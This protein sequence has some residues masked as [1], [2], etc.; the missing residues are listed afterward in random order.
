MASN[1][2]IELEIKLTL[3]PDQLEPARQSLMKHS[4]CESGGRIELRNIY[5]DTPTF[6]LNAAR[7]ALR[8]RQKGSR[9]IQTLKTQG[10]FTGG[11]HRRHEWEWPLQSPELDL[12]L[13]AETPIADAVDLQALR[14]A[15]ETNFTRDLIYISSAGDG[16]VEVALDHGRIVSGQKSLPLA[17]VEFELKSGE[18]ELL[19][20]YAKTLA[21]DVPLFLNLVSKAEQGYFLAGVEP[22]RHP[23]TG[24]QALTATEFLSILSQRW[25]TG[26]PWRPSR[27]ALSDVGQLAHQ[28]G[29]A[30]QFELL[31]VALE[32]GK[33]IPQIMQDSQTGQRV[34]QL[35]LVLAES[36]AV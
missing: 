18:P 9:Y 25:L 1:S 34:G 36:L 33:S 26:E 20:T 5:F 12:D 29:L 24:Q 22:A 10:E 30:E 3:T 27:S 6:D 35:Q 23:R 32:Q 17:E 2:A 4:S 11:G 28:A 13:L 19:M 31:V 15:F 16:F 14:P 8:V 7:S 21:R